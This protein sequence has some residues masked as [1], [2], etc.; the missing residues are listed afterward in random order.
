MT[1]GGVA[2]EIDWKVGPGTL[3]SV[4]G[5]RSTNL[6]RSYDVEGSPADIVRDPRGGEKYRTFSQELRSQG[7]TGPLAYLLGAHFSADRIPS[8]DT[9]DR[10]SGVWGKG[11]YVRVDLWC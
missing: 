5:Y 4:T 11:V 3:T 2:A 6:D 8:R 7:V 10:K 9:F 1:D